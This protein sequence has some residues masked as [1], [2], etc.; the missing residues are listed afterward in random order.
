MKKII[1]YSDHLIFIN[2]IYTWIIN[3]CKLLKD[4]YDILVLSKKYSTKVRNEINK[5]A[6]TDIWHSDIDYETDTVILNFDFGDIPTNIK[7]ANNYTILHCDYSQ[8]K[9]KV[10]I[11]PDTKYIA[12][13]EQAAK[14]FTEI[15]GL[16][17][18]NIESYI[19]YVKTKKI[20]HLTSCTR[21]MLHKGAE[22][23]YQLANLFDNEGIK[24]QWLNF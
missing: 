22:R 2:G 20:L 11:N 14:A 13:S 23:I 19:P 15:Y 18:D 5:V 4:N 12:V 21:M 6:Q 1:V 16:E 10:T 9:N 17:C 24:Y 8:V 3:F 7:A